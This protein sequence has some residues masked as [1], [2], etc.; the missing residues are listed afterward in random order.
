M[1]KALY[2]LLLPLLLTGCTQANPDS[3]V[4]V[5]DSQNTT[6]SS[7][8]KTKE[9]SLGINSDE[10]PLRLRQAVSKDDF[11]DCTIKG[12]DDISVTFQNEKDMIEYRVAP[13]PTYMSKERVV[14]YTITNP[15]FQIFGV[16]LSMN[17]SDKIF[18]FQS[19]FISVHVM[20]KAYKG[21]TRSFYFMTEDTY[22]L[23]STDKVIITTVEPDDIEDTWENSSYYKPSRISD[24]RRSQGGDTID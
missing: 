3:S 16:T 22:Y 9:S 18:Y 21:D 4:K 17:E 2:F 7:S 6:S 13:Y 12:K 15:G 19:Q 23:F 1:K 20:K 24:E 10:I 11:K 14:Q 8:E 5:T